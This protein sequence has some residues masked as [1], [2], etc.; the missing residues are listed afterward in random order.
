MEQALDLIGTAEASHIL[1]VN[2]ST[3][4]RWAADGT[5][6]VALKRPSKNGALLFHRHEVQ[7]LA[8]ERNAA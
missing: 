6:A 5:L 2:V 3:I 4:T 1:H 8:S 7:R